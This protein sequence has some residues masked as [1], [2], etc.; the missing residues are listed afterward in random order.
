MSATRAAGRPC[1]PWP[2]PAASLLAA[3]SLR[4][5]GDGFVAVLLPA[6]LL[7]LGLSPLEVGVVAT[8]SLFGSAL[9]TVVAGLLGSRYD[10]ARV[11]LACACLM[12]ATGVAFAAVHDYTL[13]LVIAFLG[14]V[15]PSAG[16]VSVFVPLEHAALTREVNALGRTRLFARYSL[17]GA[18]AAASGALAAAVPDALTPLGL[19]R[20]SAIRVMFVVYAALG[21]AGALLYARVPKRQ[22]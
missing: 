15:N 3:R 9:L 12:V 20:L 8:V 4:D 19:D 7:E 1:R 17:V 13:L 14:T 6:Y 11:L 16:S 22:L 2:G 10:P 21:L 18:L 5:F